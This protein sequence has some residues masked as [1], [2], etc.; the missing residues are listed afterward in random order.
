MKKKLPWILISPTLAMIT[1]FFIAAVIIT[2]PLAFTNMGLSFKWTF[3]GIQN[4]ESFMRDPLIPTVIINTFIFVALTLTL[5]NFGMAL[6]LSLLTTS[7][8]DKWGNFFRTIW[9]LPRITPSVV[10]GLLWLW[11]F[12]PGSDG[13]LNIL[14]RFIGIGQQDIFHHAPMVLI[15]LANG[16]VG[17]SMGMMIFSSAIK[18]I[19]IEYYRAASVD[20]AGW[21]YTTRRITL[22]LIKWHLLFIT[23]YETLSLFT[24][25]EYIYIITNGGPVNMTNVWALYTYQTAFSNF[26]FG[27]AAALSLVLVAVGIV[28]GFIYLKGINIQTNT[29]N[30]EL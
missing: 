29:K 8:N 2:I 26:S 17:A 22:P 10:F 13:L 12:D 18:S 24:S 11:I 19:P 30:I 23:T 9:M 15:V 7:I 16:Y 20:G 4:F 6:L 27:Y 25:Y 14:L 21:F 28:T 5:F 1:I 3:N